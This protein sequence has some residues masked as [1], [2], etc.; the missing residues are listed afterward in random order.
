MLSVTRVLVSFTLL[1]PADSSMLASATEVEVELHVPDDVSTFFGVT[2]A[3]D[4]RQDKVCAVR[5]GMMYVFS[6]C[7][8][9]PTVTLTLCACMLTQPAV[10][11]LLAWVVL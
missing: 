5:R 10:D 2:W 6:G 11:T 4:P 8:A 7:F 1:V 3:Q 9:I